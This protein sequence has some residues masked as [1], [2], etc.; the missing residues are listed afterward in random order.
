MK[1]LYCWL[2][3]MMVFAGCASGS[4][5]AV[6]HFTPSS[7]NEYHIVVFYETDPPNKKYQSS[8]EGMKVL[9][10]RKNI[11]AAVTYQKIETDQR[12]YEELLQVQDQQILVFDYKG[13]KFNARNIE[14]LEGMILQVANE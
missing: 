4:Q 2:V 7:Q 12:N 8:I 3:V 11:D 13:I 14:V 1:K 9:L 10:A 6:Q 5:Q